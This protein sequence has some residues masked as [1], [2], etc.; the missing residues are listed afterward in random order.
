MSFSHQYLNIHSISGTLEVPKLVFNDGISM[1]DVHIFHEA[2]TVLVDKFKKMVKSIEDKFNVSFGFN[3]EYHLDVPN[4]IQ[5]NDLNFF[6]YFE[7]EKDKKVIRY[8]CSRNHMITNCT[9][10]KFKLP[11]SI[12]TKFYLS[13]DNDFNLNEGFFTSKAYPKSF[14]LFIDESLNLKKT[15]HEESYLT[16]TGKGVPKRETITKV[17]EDLMSY[18]EELTFFY[19]IHYKN[20]LFL[21]IMPEAYISSAYDFSSPDFKQRFLM[22]S[23]VSL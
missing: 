8:E 3:F 14:N 20:E 15:M 19:L 12:D 5:I 22:A 13:F 17:S 11:N 4:I 9:G 10:F 18:E 6:L 16:V 1:L 2:K 23:I 21:E 7:N